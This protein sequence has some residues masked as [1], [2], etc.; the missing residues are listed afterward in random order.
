MWN[1]NVSHQEAT[2]GNCQP[3]LEK[4]LGV[5]MNVCCERTRASL[6]INSKDEAE[7]FF[8]SLTIF[9]FLLCL[10]SVACGILVPRIGTEPRP[11][12]V[13]VQSPNH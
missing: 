6:K 11:M 9:F 2:W 12:A 8:V 4:S 13:K 5:E 7:L 3:Q 1:T 10:C